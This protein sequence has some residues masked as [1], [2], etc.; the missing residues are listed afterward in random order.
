MPSGGAAGCASLN[1][2]C[3]ASSQI[4]SASSLFINSLLCVLCGMERRG[5]L[6]CMELIGAQFLVG[7]KIGIFWDKLSTLVPFGTKSQIRDYIGSPHFGVHE[8][9]E[10]VQNPQSRLFAVM[11]GGTPL[12]RDIFPLPFWPVACRDGG[13]GTPLCRD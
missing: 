9:K 2:L 5:L 8:G 12:C 13:G 1:I 11:G 10:R 4:L 7:C 6:L 3:L